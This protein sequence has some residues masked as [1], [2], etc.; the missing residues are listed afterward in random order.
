MPKTIV[1]CADGTWNGPGETDS[2]D[3]TATTTNVFRLFVN[4]DGRDTPDSALLGNEQERVLT[5]SNG[6]VLQWAKYLHGVGAS[7]NFLVKVLGGTVGAGLIARIVR[8]YTFISRN[9]LPG[10]R[11]FI[12]GFSR[13]AYTA[14]ALAGLIATKGLLD[15]GKNDLTDKTNAYRLGSAVWYAYRR[16]ALQANTDLLGRLQEAALDLPHFLSAAPGDDRLMAAPIEAVAVWDTVGSLGIPVFTVR[17]ARIDAFQFADRKLSDKVVHGIHAIAVDEHRAD[18]TPT[19][20]D[21]DARIIQVLFPGA[22]ADVGGGYVAAESG[23]S[24]CSLAWMTKQLVALGVAF[25]RTPRYIGAPDPSGTSHE[26]WLTA[27]WNALV[28]RARSFP[29]GLLLSQCLIDRCR[30]GPVIAGPGM[31]PSPYAPGNLAGYLNGTNP[32]Q[33]IAVA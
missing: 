9:Y 15:P 31:L 16:V 19:L 6:V 30:G 13:G 22:H 21:A 1:F 11:I 14:R 24:D 27:P 32:G 18:F 33:G 4:L 7:D 12:I 3:T 8:G 5:D 25:S 10:D 28:R 17:A 20:W 26:P 2:D 29:S 23:P